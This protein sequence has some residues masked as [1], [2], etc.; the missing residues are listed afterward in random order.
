MHLESKILVE[1]SPE[2]VWAFLGDAGN[3]AKWDRG[4]SEVVVKEGAAV[5]GEGFEFDTLAD[6]SRHGLKDRGRMS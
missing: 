3:V 6:P 1:R 5:S 2:Q 4:V